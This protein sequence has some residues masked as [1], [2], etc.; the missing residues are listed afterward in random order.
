VSRASEGIEE[1]WCE[2]RQLRAQVE[3]LELAGKRQAT[4]LAGQDDERPN[5]TGTPS[6]MTV[7][8]LTN[9]R[10]IES[11]LGLPCGNLL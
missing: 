4:L 3:Q 11:A 1:L 6:V 5:S 8:A 9:S 7:D 10:E 2:L